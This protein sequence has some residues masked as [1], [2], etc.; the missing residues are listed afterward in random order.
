MKNVL[1]L[2]VLLISISMQSQTPYG[3]EWIDPSKPHYKFPIITNG[4]YRIPFSFLQTNC[5]EIASASGLEIC[6]YSN[7]KQIPLFLSWTSSPT[8]ADFIE[9]YGKRLDAEIDKRLYADSNHVLNPF[10]SLFKDTNYY[11][12]TL[13]PGSNA[14]ITDYVNDTTSVSNPYLGYCIA[15]AI[16]HYK[17]AYNDGRRWYYSATEYSIRPS[18]DEGEG[19]GTNAYTSLSIPTPNYVSPAGVNAKLRARLFGRNE[20]SHNLEFRINGTSVGTQSANGSTMINFEKDLNASSIT[21]TSTALAIAPLITNNHG[22]CLG[23]ASLSYPRDFNFNSLN[24]YSFSL[25]ISSGSVRFQLSNYNSANEIV[26][27]DLTNNT[28]TTHQPATAHRFLVN[29]Q[30]DKSLLAI[31]P[32]SAILSIS[33]TRKYDFGN[34]LTQRGNFLLIANRAMQLDS[35]GADIIA[36]YKTYKESVAG[37]GFQVVIAYMDELQEFFGYGQPKHP[38][39]IRKYLQWS[40]TWSGGSAQH[41]LLVGKGY[42]VTSLF[43]SVGANFTTNYIPSFGHASSDYHY[44]TMDGSD[45]QFMGLGRLA[46]TN[47][48]TVRNYLEKLK[49]YNLEYYATSDADQRPDKKEYMKWLVNLGGGTGVAQQ[50]DYRANLQSYEKIAADSSYGARTF[51]VFKNGPDI[52]EDITSVDLTNRINKGVSLITFF[53]H[54]S[55]TIFDVGIGEPITFTNKGKYPIFL[56]NGCNSGF[57]YGGA[58]S[59]SENFINLKDKGAIGFLATTNTALDAALYQY[60]DAFFRQ[61]SKNSYNNTIGQVA[62]N[63]SQSLL[64][65]GN[66]NY[67]NTTFM[68]YNLNGDPSVPIAQYAKPDYYIGTNSVLFPTTN[69]NSTMDSFSIKI[70]IQNLGKAIQANIKIKIERLNNGN[71]AVY[72]KTVPAIIFKDTFD[73]YLPIRDQNYGLGINTFNIKIDADESISEISEAN[74]EIK[75]LGNLLIENDDIVPIFPYDFSIISNTTAKLTAM[76]TMLNRPSRSYVFQLDTSEEFNS[77]QLKTYKTESSSESI[78]SWLPSTVFQD[79]SVYYWRVSKDSTPGQ[80]YRW[81][82]SSF[83]YLPSQPL[84]GWNQSHYDQ[85]LKNT[86]KNIVYDNTRRFKFVNDVKSISFKI[87][88]SNNV[89]DTEWYLNNARQAVLREA[90]R[91][92]NGIFVIWIDGKSGLTKP[93]LDSNFGTGVWGSNG[94]IQ[95]GYPGLP[96]WGFV[97]QDTGKTPANHPFPNTPWSTVMLNFINQVPDGDYLIFYSN[98]RPV[99][100][101]WSNDLKNYFFNAGFSSLQQLIDSVVVAPFIFGYRKNTPSFPIY[102]KL[103]T[104]YTNFTTG[105]MFINGSWKEGYKESVNVGP[106]R[107]WHTLNYRLEAAEAP[108]ND[109]NSVQLFGIRANKQKELLKT[110]YNTSL[111]TSIEWIDPNTYYQLQLMLNSKDEKDRTPTQLRHWRVFYEDIGEIA[112]NNIASL[113]PKMRDTIENGENMLLNFGVETLNSNSFDSITYTITISQGTQSKVLQGKTAPMAGNSFLLVQRELNMSEYFEGVNSVSYEIN[114]NQA[115]Y[116]KEKYDINNYSK[117]GFFVK[118]DVEN[119]LLDVTFD[120]VHII[121]NELV[122]STPQI[123]IALK[124]ENKY[125][126]LNDTALINLSLRYPDGSVRPIYFSQ[127]GLQYTLATA[128]SKNIAEI[129]YK[130]TLTDGSYQLIVKDKDKAG[131]SSSPNGSFN[132]KISFQVITKNQISHFINYP[133]PF[134]TSTQ[135]VFTLTGAKVPDFIKIQIINIRGQVVKE[136]FKE[137]LGPLKLGINRTQYAWDGKDQY[138]D[139]LANGVYLYKVTVKNNG[140]DIPMMDEKDFNAINK[141]TKNLGQYYKDGWG[142]MVIIR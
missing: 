35:S 19:W 84:G 109:I 87:N 2:G 122:S 85:F 72:E 110:F 60:G 69:L 74:N 37:G 123:R 86:Y 136:I 79:S 66:M 70:I 75:N 95:F 6:I 59:Y 57:Y 120:G 78:Y 131:N 108:T 27:Y 48:Q 62:K 23:F 34:L 142:K 44:A 106:T 29:I 13:R 53:G 124:D 65:S 43:A 14:R 8:A 40:Q 104:N 119:P 71:S 96:R 90:G 4:I 121:N 89:F 49:E 42:T 99:Y 73:F 41:A 107:K 46:V 80:G 105:D 18:F 64:G 1:L 138:G 50:A 7:G 68:E 52:S 38:I 91:M 76:S 94:S 20:L 21:S 126:L 129:N 45:V 98:K 56:A 112:M 115:G 92:T 141:T 36:E 39:A 25:P 83:I 77:P 3:H 12:I 133:N 113:V 16:N 81:N 93:S 63:A 134:T 125:L 24:Q 47:G 33:Y 15:N 9:F 102:Q 11:Y 88:G 117:S 61:M 128:G 32:T 137:D 82:T 17:V 132:Y 130:P 116:Q 101:F 22:Y 103:G 26:L 54:S 97:F 5:P 55:A 31:T 28:R 118:T 100:K 139:I 67:L 58:L 140:E 51:S 30:N 135:F 127:P 111:D 114:P 10:T